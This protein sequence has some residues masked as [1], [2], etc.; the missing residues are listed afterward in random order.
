MIVIDE[1]CGAQEEEEGETRGIWGAEPRGQARVEI[2]FIFFPKPQPHSLFFSPF[3]FISPV[4][5]VITQGW[6]KTSRKVH[7][8]GFFRETTAILK[9]KKKIQ[10]IQKNPLLVENNT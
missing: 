10:K 7:V 5:A 8:L 2:P 3:I 1:K 9:R 6:D 4:S